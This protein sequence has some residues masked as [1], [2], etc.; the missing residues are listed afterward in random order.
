MNAAHRWF[1]AENYGEAFYGRAWTHPEGP[2]ALFNH[3][4]AWLRRNRVLLPGASVL[5]R[6]VSAARAVAERRLHTTV[7]RAVRRADPGISATL[8]SLLDVP[9]GVRFSELERLRRRPT[10]S[11]GTAMARALERVEEIASFGLGYW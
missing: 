1:F 8:V 4:V 7:A 2:V 3:A 11:T 9:E 10:R 5:A 6:Q